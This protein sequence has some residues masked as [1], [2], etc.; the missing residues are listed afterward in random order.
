MSEMRWTY[1]S[2][3]GLPPVWELE[4]WGTVDFN[5]PFSEKWTATPIDGLPIGWPTVLSFETAEAAM[6]YVDQALSSRGEVRA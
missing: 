2:G 4:G 6:A 5:G 3:S 1:H